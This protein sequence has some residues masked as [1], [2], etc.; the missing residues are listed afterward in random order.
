M[1]ENNDKAASVYKRGADQGWKLG[2]YLTAMFLCSAYSLQIPFAGLV[3]LAMLVVLPLPVYRVLARDYRRYPSMR[4]FSAVWMHGIALFFFGSLIMA[5][6][7]Y[8]FLRFVQPG[9]VLENVRRAIVLYRELGV[10]MPE[11]AAMADNLQTMVDK[12]LLPSA[13][14]LA[15]TTIWTVTFGGSMLTLVLTPVVRVLNRNK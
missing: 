3:S 1:T 6:A 12:H 11:A 2:L 10:Q 8:V 7:V 5:L 14:S 4:F 15:F 9:F 13:I